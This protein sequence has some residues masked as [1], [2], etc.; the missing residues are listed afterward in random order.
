MSH[1]DRFQKYFVRYSNLGFSIDISRMAFEDDIFSKMAPR[2][3][4]AYK[5]MI[6]LEAGAI[7]NPDE[8][9][10]VGHYWLRNARLAPND[11]LQHEIS[12]T[13]AA[14]LKFA[15][16]VHSGAITAANGQKFTRVLVVGIGGSALGP[17]LVAHAITPAN[18]PLAISFLDNTDP[19]GIDRVMAQI[20]DELATTLT[21]VISKSGGTKETRNG[22]LEAETAYKAAGLDFAKHAVAVTGVGSELDKHSTAQGWLTRFPMWDWVGGRTS[23]MSAVGTLAAALQ[24]V[25]VLQFLAGAA[26]MDVETRQRPA[27]EN[28]A[29]LLALMWHQAGKGQGLKDMVVLPYKDRLVL[30]SKY[31]QQLV[32]ES[33]GK[34]HDLNGAVVNQGIAVYGNKGSTDQHAYVQQLRDGVN[35]FFV[36]FI[37]VAKSRD[38]ASLEV[39]PGF[40]TGDYLQGFLRGTRKA[41]AEKG[42]ESITLTIPEL[43]AFT[44]G[45]LIGLFERAVSFYASLVN[46]NAYHQPGVEAG[47]KA[48]TDFLTQL[49]K[50][51]ATLTATGLTA[52][53]VASKLGIDAEDAF[54]MLN[55]LAANAQARI[56][57]A[58]DSSALDQFAAP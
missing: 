7:A 32:M 21:I 55:H 16:D 49:S 35:N 43:N 20:G 29:M 28:A 31:L 11:A 18:P 45:M 41:L 51:R 6:E 1:W 5:A 27:I 47:K 10:M 12:E 48:A 53:E 34:E 3:E 17:Q 42:R 15:A 33:L 54:H 56:V 24:G 38:T 39:D 8:Q 44:L 57:A 14:T 25:D 26:A 9:R 13:L 52:D 37:E 30:F 46:I 19:D 4:S 2:I 40:T 22:M 36:T 50:V 58:G 23:L